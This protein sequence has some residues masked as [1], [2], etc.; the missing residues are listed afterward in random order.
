MSPGMLRWRTEREM[1]VALRGEDVGERVGGE[2]DG[3]DVRG[4][5]VGEDLDLDLAGE[6]EEI[7]AQALVP[8]WQYC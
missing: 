1:A 8:A 7:V 3:E 6:G 2:A 5:E 4:G